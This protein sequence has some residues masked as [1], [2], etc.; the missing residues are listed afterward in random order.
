MGPPVPF[1]SCL[2]HFPATAHP[3]PVA[4]QSCPLTLITLAPSC[5]IV[6][7]PHPPYFALHSSF[8]KSRLPLEKEGRER[9]EIAKK[10]TR[11]REDESTCREH[12][13]RYKGSM[14]GGRQ[15]PSIPLPGATPFLSHHR[16]RNRLQIASGNRTTAWDSQ[17]RCYNRMRARFLGGSQESGLHE[18]RESLTPFSPIF[19]RQVRGIVSQA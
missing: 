1:L 12:T 10:R 16:P 15:T 13:H 3:H 18:T 2:Q 6:R 7:F 17:Q 5:A 9:E 14:G 8:P 19:L 11:Q 4:L